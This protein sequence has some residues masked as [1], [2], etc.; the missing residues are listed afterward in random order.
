MAKVAYLPKTQDQNDGL[1]PLPL[2]SFTTRKFS[3]LTTY[4]IVG[5]FG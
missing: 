3:T 2:S 4:S 5:L 1:P